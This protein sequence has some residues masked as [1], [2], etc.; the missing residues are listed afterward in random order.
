MSPL[1]PIRPITARTF[2]F[3]LM[4]SRPGE[5]FVYHVGNLMVDRERVILTGTHRDVDPVGRK[6]DA[7]RR[8]DA[9]DPEFETRPIAAVDAVARAVWAAYR[10][11][12]VTLKQRRLGPGYFAY[13]ARREQGRT[14]HGFRDA[15]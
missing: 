5:E 2:R 1:V 9:D 4:S 6:K 3:W 7:A 11:G 13:I 15:A 8:D 10:R 14:E 12:E